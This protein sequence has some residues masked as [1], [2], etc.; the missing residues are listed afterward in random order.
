MANDYF[1]SEPKGTRGCELDP[2]FSVV[3][4]YAYGS[5]KGFKLVISRK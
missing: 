1:V 4:P 5:R 3:G 2:D